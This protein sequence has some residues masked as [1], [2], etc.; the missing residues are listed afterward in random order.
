MGKNVSFKFDAF[1]K[2][3]DNLWLTDRY[4]ASWEIERRFLGVSF[5]YFLFINENE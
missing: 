1:F 2:V 5:F 3:I 4:V